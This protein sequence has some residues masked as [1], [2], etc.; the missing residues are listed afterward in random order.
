MTYRTTNFPAPQTSI[1][2]NLVTMA[3][4]AVV[5][6]CSYLAWMPAVTAYHDMT[7]PKAHVMSAVKMEAP[8]WT[9]SGVY[10]GDGFI[11]TAG[12]VTAGLRSID[13]E[14]SD[15]NKVKAE[16]LWTNTP[17]D[18]GYDVSL[19]YAANLPAASAPLSCKPT[20]TGEAV[21]IIGNPDSLTFLQSWGRV[22]GKVTKGDW[23]DWKS[24]VAL[25][26]VAAPGVSGGPVYNNNGDVVGI[27]VSGLS[28]ARGNY[29]YTFM[30]PST[31]ICMMLGRV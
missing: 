26:V 9:G 20:A 21:T 28:D 13:V 5:V 16:V 15:G 4:A 24:L 3:I 8:G 7:T 2:V 30:V 17:T 19:V 10:L 25:D 6:L 1:L 29:G 12:H 14:L 23:G 31:T 18:G 27:L 22:S 11:I